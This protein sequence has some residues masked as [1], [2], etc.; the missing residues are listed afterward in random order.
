MLLHCFYLFE[1]KFMFEFDF[2]ISFRKIAKG[3]L[4]LSPACLVSRAAHLRPK[5]GPRRLSPPAGAARWG[6]V[7]IPDL[8]PDPEPRPSPTGLN[9]APARCP[10]PWARAS[11]P[12]SPFK[13]RRRTE[14]PRNPS[15]HRAAAGLE[16]LGHRRPSIP[17]VVASPPTR[18]SLGAS[19]GR[20]EAAGATFVRR[21]VLHRRD[22]VA[23]IFP[24]PLSAPS[25][26]LLSSS[27]VSP[28]LCC[29]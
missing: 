24:P 27:H 26:F 21:R 10:W 7:V 1:F 12:P 9:S 25:S 2:V 4:F 22:A 18:S 14:A 6:P 28:H 20:E 15:R 8:R 29:S 19:H 5:A 23:E 16:T 3:F 13:G 11:R 17:S